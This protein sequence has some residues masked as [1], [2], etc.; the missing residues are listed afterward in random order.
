[1]PQ[2]GVVEV[3]WVRTFGD[4]GL[5]GVGDGGHD[6]VGGA[7]GREDRERVL[8]G[9]SAEARVVI[10]VP[11]AKPES[12]WSTFW[13]FI[14]G[15]GSNF[16]NTACFFLTSPKGS[17]DPTTAKVGTFGNL[18][19]VAPPVATGMYPQASSEWPVM[20]GKEYRPEKDG[21]TTT[22][23]RRPLGRRR[24]LTREARKSPS[25]WEELRPGSRSEPR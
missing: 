9:S 17:L 16:L 6:V 1:M 3:C 8:F 15:L 2:L 19:E 7:L 25:C 22:A 5:L 13:P 18:I 4:D 24:A 12:I 11:Q 23:E 14:E 20:K 21:E 10:P